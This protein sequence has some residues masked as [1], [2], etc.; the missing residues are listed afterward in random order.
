MCN[1]W[2][3]KI[4]ERTIKSN[5]DM[6]GQVQEHLA[7][8]MWAISTNTT[9]PTTLRRLPHGLCIKF[10]FNCLYLYP[11]T[12]DNSC[13]DI[14]LSKCQRWSGI[15][16]IFLTFLQSISMWEWLSVCAGKAWHMMCRRERGS[17]IQYTTARNTTQSLNF[18]V[19]FSVS[20]TLPDIPMD[21]RN[22]G[23]QKEILLTVCECSKFNYTET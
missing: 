13:T 15:G 17:L 21:T 9:T 11:Q 16:L 2:I 5:S 6:R 10:I 12:W 19:I 14:I 3:L 22:P 18:L 20:Y 4:F 8:W 7:F 23:W 1:K